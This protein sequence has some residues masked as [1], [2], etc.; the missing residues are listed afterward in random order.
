MLSL[1]PTTDLKDISSLR[2]FSIAWLFPHADLAKDPSNRLRRYQISHHLSGMTGIVTRSENFFFYDKKPGLR[3]QLL[4]YDVVV[5]FNIN[6]I[7]RDLV[8][9]LKEK[10]KIVIFDHAEN[11]F[12][13]G[14]EEEI[15]KNVSAITC[16]STALSKM[17][18]D[19][20]LKQKLGI[21]K[22]VFTIRDPLDDSIFQYARPYPRGDNV[23]LV[24][25][26]GANVQYVLPTLEKFCAEAQYDI[27]IL[28][29]AGFSF[30]G[31]QVEYWTP[32]TWISHANKCSVALCY[33]SVAQF[34][35]KGN[36]K[37]TTPMSLG[38]P[39]IAVPIEAYTEA[40]TDQYDGFIAHTEKMWV[41]YL[42][43]L[44]RR[45]TRNIFGLRAKQAAITKY[46]TQKIALDYLSM[47]SFLL[48]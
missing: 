31:H 10:G 20:Y 24:M 11:L 34:P 5:L 19:I 27:L 43:Y 29:E 39:V 9:F 28:T 40:I 8:L 18:H 37:V 30:P 46:S 45:G 3:E 33:H 25:G 23:A 17:T 48:H 38:L 35:C 41:D 22:P 6:E 36:V 32:Y 42:V 14:F 4:N 15:M 7:D 12:G 16:C 1:N 26:M 44:K 21:D 2:P 47:I 13:L